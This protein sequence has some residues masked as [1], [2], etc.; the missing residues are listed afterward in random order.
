MV[1]CH[2][3]SASVHSDFALF[4]ENLFTYT[5]LHAGLNLHALIS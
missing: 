3:V 1:A 2:R 4:D 5:N